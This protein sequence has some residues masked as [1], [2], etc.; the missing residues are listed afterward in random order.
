MIAW[1]PNDSENYERGYGTAQSD[2]TASSISTIILTYT[3]CTT[4]WSPD[5]PRDVVRVIRVVDAIMSDFNPEWCNAAPKLCKSFHVDD[6]VANAVAQD[7]RGVEPPARLAR[8][9][10][11]SLSYRL[12]RPPPRPP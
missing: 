8:P 5:E 1:C 12:A 6:N 9:A 10:Q 3:T 2:N 7:D 4:G 11:L